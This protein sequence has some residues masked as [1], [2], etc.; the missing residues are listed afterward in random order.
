MSRPGVGTA[1]VG[2][3]AGE[4]RRAPVW[5]ANKLSSAAAEPTECFVNIGLVRSRPGAV[6]E[7]R[8]RGAPRRARPIDV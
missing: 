5:P 2:R 3:R 4:R 1:P 8:P 6:A 7:R